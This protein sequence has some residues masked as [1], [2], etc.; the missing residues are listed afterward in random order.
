MDSAN[1]QELL[2]ARFG[3]NTARWYFAP[4]SNALRLASIDGDVTVA[5]KLDAHQADV[6]RTID[7]TKT[8]VVLPMAI[9]GV[10][11]NLLLEG[12]KE[13]ASQWSGRAAADPA[14]LLEDMHDSGAFAGTLKNCGEVA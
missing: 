8:R 3:G 2:F 14:H 10:E 9:D 12:R 4:D 1:V 11:F 5:V 13:N 6:I 7:H